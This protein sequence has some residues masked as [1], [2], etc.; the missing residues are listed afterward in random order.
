M[1]INFVHI[2]KTAGTSFR[3]GA[4][5]S[6]GSK[7]IIYD[8]GANSQ[9]TSKLVRDFAYGKETDFVKIF[10][11]CDK[12][13]IRMISGHMPFHKYLAGCGARNTIAFV[14]NPVQRVASE[15]Y[16]HV[17]NNNLKE[18][19][20]S[21]YRQDKNRER[22]SKS[23][24]AMPLAAFGFLGITESYSKSLEQINAV[25]GLS[26][27]GLKLNQ[28]E[29]RVENEYKFSEEVSEEIKKLNR[30]DMDLYRRSCLLFTERARLARC[31]NPWAHC[32]ATVKD[33]RI[34]G[35]AW[36][37]HSDE[38][39]TLG[40]YLNGKLVDCIRAVDFCAPLC[41]FFVPRKSYV[42]F[43]VRVSFSAADEV[44]VRV[45]KTGQVIVNRPGAET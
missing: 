40:V 41:R 4:E 18:S 36:W 11:I 30:K 16:H 15:Y 22:Q 13:N 23:L 20:E 38:P 8:Y 25:Y 26:V 31:G 9:D 12:D 32:A 42:G 35:W 10:G 3:I 24:G 17:R 39:V 6:F 34:S 37:A 45:E 33:G 1:M 43:N 19:F 7:S 29:K 21:F 27:P 44:Q 2:P 5:K 28:G 14:R